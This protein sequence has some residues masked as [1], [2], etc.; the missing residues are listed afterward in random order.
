MEIDLLSSEFLQEANFNNVAGVQKCRKNE[1]TVEWSK[2]FNGWKN[3]NKLTSDR[4][5]SFFFKSW[6]SIR[7]VTSNQH[8][9]SIGVK[10]EVLLLPS[11]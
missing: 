3:F 1:I 10:K 2:D 6:V 5:W 8:Y 7:S 11:V 4:F 9:H